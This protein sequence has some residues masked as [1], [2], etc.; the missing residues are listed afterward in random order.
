MKILVVDDSKLARMAVSKVLNTMYPD[1]IRIEA[2]NADEALD[3]VKSDNPDIAVFDF[4]MPGRDGLTLAAEVLA[5]KPSMPL[6]IISANHQKE[7]VDRAH[8]I[9]AT[10]LGKPVTEPA[11]K[12]FMTNAALSLKAASR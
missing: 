12:E 11:L 2:A 9:G 5:L 1:C 4:N 8:A 7:V 6:A 3:K 10:F